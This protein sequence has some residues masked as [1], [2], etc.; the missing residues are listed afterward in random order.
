MC[1]FPSQNIMI[2][3]RTAP[4][5]IAIPNLYSTPTPTSPP[6]FKNLLP[7]PQTATIRIA[8]QPL[9][10]PLHTNPTLLVPAKRNPRINIKVAIH[11]HAPR[12]QSPRH[13]LR[14][15][16][17]PAPDGC[18]QPAAKRIGPANNVVL[19]G[20]FEERDNGSKGLFDDDA[21]VFG[22]VVDDGGGDEEAV[23]VVVVVVG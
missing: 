1:L 8:L 12:L 2:P 6:P 18:A 4:A 13:A 9:H 14:A 3:D 23:A 10:T 21:R 11:P 20:P 7:N 17:I 5:T 19:V 22:R 16:E 15:P